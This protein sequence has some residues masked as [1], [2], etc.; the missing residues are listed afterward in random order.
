MYFEKAT[1]NGVMGSMHFR[2][3]VKLFLSPKCFVHNNDLSI[4]ID[5]KIL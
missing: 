4:E 2:R 3:T 1:E 5:K